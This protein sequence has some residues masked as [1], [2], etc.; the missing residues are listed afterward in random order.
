M[1]LQ[2]LTGAFG[3]EVEGLNL[4]QGVNTRDM[5]L[6]AE[7]LA[8][9]SV[10]VFRDQDLDIGQFEDLATSMGE[11]G[12][13]PFITPVEGHPNVLKVLREADEEGPLFGSGWH[14]DWSFQAQPPSSTL[15]YGVDIPDVG[16]DTVFTSQYLAYETLSDSMKSIVNDLKGIHSAERSYGPKGT[17]GR[18][19]PKASMDINGDASA[20][21]HQLHPLV[22]THP[23][24]GRKALF[25]NEVY[26]VGVEGLAPAES[27][28]LLSFLFEHSKQ[29]GFTCRVRWARGTLTIW[30]NRTTQHFAI[31]DYAG[32]RREMYRITLAG[33]QP[34]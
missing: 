6:I 7:A 21:V 16:G 32:S 12:E 5:Q 13:T 4:G 9:K 30:D 22:R 18:P 31:N 2:A 1:K 27:D 33:E 20:T 17:F 29:I 15:L 24:S 14:S 8:E 26:T 3:A 25:V 28:Y 23:V 19:D 11:F 34:S 10:L